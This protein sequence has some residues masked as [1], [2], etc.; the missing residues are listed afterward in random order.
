MINSRWEADDRGFRNYKGL[1]IIAFPISD[2]NF[3]VKIKNIWERRAKEHQVFVGIG[4]DM[5]AP[6]KKKRFD[7][8][9]EAAIEV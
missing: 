8:N 1:F 7:K 6:V 2:L 9:L 4:M 5:T 3:C